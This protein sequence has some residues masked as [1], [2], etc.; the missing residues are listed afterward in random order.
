M[1]FPGEPRNY[2]AWPASSPEGARLPAAA[3]EGVR[4]RRMFAVLLDVVLVS[5]LSAMLFVGLIFLSFGT[6]LFLLPPMFPLVAFF[7]NGLTVSGWRRA[8][9]GMQFMD[10]EVRMMDGRPVPFINAAAHAVLFYVTWLFP[11]LLLVSLITRDKR[12]L[13]DILADVVVLRRVLP[14]PPGQRSSEP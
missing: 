3:L 2:E 11:P 5:L 10:L 9:P 1:V 14:C 13:H 8:T 6:S 12:C 7:Y 4:T